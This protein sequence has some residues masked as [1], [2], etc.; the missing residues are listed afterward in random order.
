MNDLQR[1]FELYSAAYLT[2]DAEA[3]VPFFHYPCIVHDLAGV[4]VLDSDEAVCRYEKLMLEMLRSNDV[5]FID[6]QVRRYRNSESPLESLSC[7]L[8]YDLRNSK[9][10][11]VLDFD[12]HYV[13]L[14]DVGAWKIL[15]AEIGGVRAS[16]VEG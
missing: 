2:F 13:L 9:K 4:H 16:L 15:F 7:T 6:C 10:E 11:T 14:G 5:C 8:S 12:Y 3:L 1:Y